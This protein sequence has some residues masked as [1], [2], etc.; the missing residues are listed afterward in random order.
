MEAGFVLLTKAT[1]VNPT[2]FSSTFGLGL[3]QYHLG[4]TKEAVESFRRAT[5]LYAKSPDAFIWLG[6]ALKR[7]SILNEAE[8]TFKRA[9]ELAKG[10]SAEV[11][12]QL[13][14]LYHEQARYKEAADEFELFLKVQP[15]STDAEKIRELI[16]QLREKAAK[17]QS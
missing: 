12:W 5:N 4:M 9:N 3:T 17:A 10:K 1:E 13:A 6:K 2:S 14:G 16:R 7:V 15:H 11:H 8:I